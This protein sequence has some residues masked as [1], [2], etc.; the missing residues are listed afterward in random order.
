MTYKRFFLVTIISLLASFSCSQTKEKTGLPNYPKYKE[1]AKEFFDNY[2]VEKVKYPEQFML[3]KKPDG[4]HAMIIESGNKTTINDELFW[5]RKGKKYLSLD[6]QI[7]MGA[8]YDERNHLITNYYPNYYTGIIPYW[9]YPGWERDVISEYGNKE[10]LSD[11]LLNSLARTYSNIARNLIMDTEFTDREIHFDIPKGQ[12]ALSEKQLSE[13]L[14]YQYL[15]NEYYYK[16]WKENPSF[17]NMVTDAFNLYSNEIV[18]GYLTLRYFQNEKVA[19]KL[20]KPGLYDAF[21]LDMARNYLA[22]CD[23]NAILFVNGDM[24][25]FPLLYVQ[26]NEKFRQ[27]V[28]VVNLSFL[29]LGRYINHLANIKSVTDPIELSLDTSIYKNEVNR[30]FL[31]VE[32]LNKGV[33][34]KDL[35]KF[36]ASEDNKTKYQLSD[37]EFVNYIPTKELYLNIDKEN[38][39]ENEINKLIQ[40]DTSIN[41]KLKKRY[42]TIAEF[43]ILDIIAT[44]NFKRPVYYATTTARSNYLGFE[45]YFQLEGL[46]YRI[47]PFKS[48]EANNQLGRVDF[49]TLYNK[50]FNQF[51]FDKKAYVNIHFS[52]SHKGIV[53]KY[54]Q[55]FSRLAEELIK[56]E[57]RDSALK[58]LDFCID[59]FPTAKV[60]HNFYSISIIESYFKLNKTVKAKGLT[61]DYLK[62]IIGNIE[63]FNKLSQSEGYNETRRHYYILLELLKINK[64]YIPE[65]KLCIVIEDNIKSIKGKFKL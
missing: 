7:N 36:V 12:N 17:E 51:V 6:Y 34:I 30:Y 64:E 32:K 58:V 35:M 26:K 20:L 23:S 21:F 8:K 11:S 39:T 13:F 18:N 43:C 15:A 52:K 5:S 57:N 50:I 62:T 46:A 3:A 53:N 10:N 9:G 45:P 31:I 55:T 22:S 25:T 48:V 49:K 41:I 33:N 38:L 59:L 14:K 42:L 65:D 47:S 56:A 28:L 29:N 60:P 40:P 63:D 24:D 4:W 61:E 37:G 54:K 44:N 16:L 2:S 19:E 27:D 1:V